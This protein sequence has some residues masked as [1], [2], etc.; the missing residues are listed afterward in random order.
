MIQYAD[1]IALLC[2]DVD[3]LAKIVNIYDR[4]FT[5]F[6]LKIAASKTETMVFNVSE[7]VKAKPSLISIGNVPIKNLHKFKYLGH[8]VTNLDDDPSHFLFFRIA[9]AF[10]KWNKLK[11]VFTDKE[12][13]CQ[14]V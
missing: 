1:D 5:R 3:E 10:Q 2:T 8:M 13:S 12:L 4:T 7:D 14:L 9:S 11:H 6:G